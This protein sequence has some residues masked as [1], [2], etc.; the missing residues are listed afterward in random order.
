MCILALRLWVFRDINVNSPI[1]N[2]DV[3]NIF[4]VVVLCCSCCFITFLFS[5]SYISFCFPSVSSALYPLLCSRNLVLLYLFWDGIC[6]WFHLKLSFLLAGK[7]RERGRESVVRRQIMMD[8][9]AVSCLCFIPISFSFCSALKH[10]ILFYMIYWLLLEPSG[11][12]LQIEGCEIDI[13][14]FVISSL[15]S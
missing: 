4:N 13:Y 8:G 2:P 7:E 1:A 10:T 11:Y 9:F 5:F 3:V 15:R 14:K 12:A 6:F